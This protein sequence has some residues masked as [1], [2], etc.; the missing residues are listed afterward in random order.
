[1]V[2]RL[3]LMEQDIHMQGLLQKSLTAEGYEVTITDTVSHLQGILHTGTCDLV[4]IDGVQPDLDTLTRRIRNKFSVAIIVIS[5]R[6][7]LAD[8]IADQDLSADDYIVKPFLMTELQARI[9]R[10][11]RHQPDSLSAPALRQS[12]RF[13]GWTLDIASRT[14]RDE[15]GHAVALTTGEYQLLE[16]FAHHCG[17]VLSRTELLARLHAQNTP[18]Y[19][20]SIDVAIMRLRRKLGDV[21]TSSRLIKTIRGG[22][23]LFT[24]N[25]TSGT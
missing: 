23:Y 8:R 3:V 7:T 11:L 21:T 4:I 16:T 17:H 2:W 18:A 20:R 14:L 6:D 10:I 1:M 24:A 19:D 22:G 25:V 12:L 5:S 15:D 13:S 9:R